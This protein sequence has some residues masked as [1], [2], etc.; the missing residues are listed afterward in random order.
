MIR[1][2]TWIIVL[3]FIALVGA[4]ILWQRSQKEKT[5]EATP[6]TATRL[7]LFDLPEKIVFMR[8]D[9][10][11]DRQLELQRDAQ[12]NWQMT[13]PAGMQVDNNALD[14]ALSQLA[15]LQVLSTL[16]QPP[17]L[18]VLGLDKPAY[19]LLIKMADGSQALANVGK[20]TPTGSGYYVLSGDRQIVVVDKTGMDAILQMV[21]TPPVLLVPQ[22]TEMNLPVLPTP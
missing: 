14:P 22:S 11:G 5:P 20:E 12:D 13:S 19:R 8:L 15:V 3:V 2:S 18:D 10:V 17:A 9:R 7:Y 21:D 16:E 6:T 1:K 4:T